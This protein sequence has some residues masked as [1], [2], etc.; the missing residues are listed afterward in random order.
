M[1]ESLASAGAAVYKKLRRSRR[2]RSVLAVTRD[3]NDV[4]Q[5]ANDATSD[6]CGWHNRQPVCRLTE[7]GPS[8]QLL[9]RQHD[10]R[11]SQPD[12]CVSE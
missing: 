1:S 8:V 11:S 3:D 5:L 12:R 2:D 6:R 4:R 10:H 7:D 9:T